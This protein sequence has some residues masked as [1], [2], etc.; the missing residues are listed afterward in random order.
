MSSAFYYL[1]LLFGLNGS[2]K[3][4]IIPKKMLTEEELRG[5][6]DYYFRVDASQE[7]IDH[8]V[9]ELIEV[10]AVTDEGDRYRICDDI[11]AL[12][13]P[14]PKPHWWNLSWDDGRWGFYDALK[15]KFEAK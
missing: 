10:H 1:I 11:L 3:N 2:R 13:I 14:K 9:Q 12:Y 8:A 6:L 15:A 4:W 7:E 5:F